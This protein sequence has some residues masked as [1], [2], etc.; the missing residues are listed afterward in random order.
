[1]FVLH[2]YL[3]LTSIAGYTGVMKRVG[4]FAGTFDPVHE[5]HI[6]FALHAAQHC[7]LD[8]VYLMPERQP[9]RKYNVSDISVR[10]QLIQQ[11]T[12]K[13]TNLDTLMFDE[14]QFSVQTT[15]P[16]LQS[17]FPD[18]QLVFLIGSDVACDSLAHWDELGTLARTV[19]FVVGVRNTHDNEVVAHSL[20]AIVDMSIPLHY[21]VVASP[22]AHLS[23]SMMRDR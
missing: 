1:M 11:R 19:E 6:A 18:A 12:A 21:S 3:S 16:A 7:Q 23:S 2:I 22:H 20:Q 13:H 9:R 8:A 5:G 4:I 15:L 14:S 10:L 17:R